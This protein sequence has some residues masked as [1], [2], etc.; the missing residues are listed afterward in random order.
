MRCDYDLIIVGGG[1]AG[2]CLALALKDS[3]LRIALIE[4]ETATARKH[5]P[6]GQRALA[7]AY[8]SSIMLAALDL[9]EV[10]KKT[11]TPIKHIH[12][13]DQ[14]H[15]G[16]TRLSAE[17]EGVEA[18]GYVITAQ[19]IESYVS[20]QAS[21]TELTT[22]CPARLVGLLS[23]DEAAYVNLKVA[24]KSVN[25]TAKLVIGADGGQSTVRQ[26]LAIEQ[27]TTEYYQKAIVTTVRS[28]LGHDNVAYERFTD[29][30]PL[31]ILPTTGSHSSVVWTRKTENADDLI[32]MSDHDFL[33]E[34]QNC[35]GYRMGSLELA[36]PRFAFP[37]N[38]IRAEKMV[39]GRA[40]I[41]GN[42][43]HQLHPVAGQGFNLG[44]RDILQLAEMLIE[45]AEQEGDIGESAFLENY[46]K[47]R[48]IDHDKVVSFTDGLVRVFSNDWVPVAV[49][50]NTALILLDHVSSVKSLVTQH[51]MGLGGRLQRIGKRR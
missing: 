34:L 38:L 23:S 5:A 35:F 6:I 41:V 7:L 20:E 37:V 26:L 40:V 11:A 12:V 1:L 49:S 3:G 19:H 22:Y 21:K 47:M 28:S 24:Q 17:K 31:A 27:K 45:Q 33:A 43:V 2:N 15:F 18:L 16:K 29:E 44:L 8:G 14:G 48:Q 30:G 36:G 25:L 51:A 39:K 46:A 4:A 32:Q 13:S 9:W 50:R 42:A 10:I